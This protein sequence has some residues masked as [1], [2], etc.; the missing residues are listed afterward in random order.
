MPLPVRIPPIKPLTIK[1]LPSGK[2]GAS[3]AIVDRGHDGAG[4]LVGRRA[5]QADQSARLALT[6]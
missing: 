3:S 5:G 2:G 1:V 4:A 6:W